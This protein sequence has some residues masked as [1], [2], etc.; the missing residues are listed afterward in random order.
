MGDLPGHDAAHVRLIGWASLGDAELLRR[1]A[2]RFDAFITV[3]RGFA[4]QQNL[5]HF[6]L[7]VVILR[8]KR[9]TR[10][11]LQSFLP[12]LLRVLPRAPQGAVT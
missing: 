6:K 8:T 11:S 5:D 7:A 12:A 3:D 10:Q 9:N 2:G 4:Y 1:A